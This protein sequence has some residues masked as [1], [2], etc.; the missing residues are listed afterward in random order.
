MKAARLE[1][2]CV[3][4][5]E[6]VNDIVASLFLKKRKLGEGEKRQIYTQYKICQIIL[7]T[8]MTTFISSEKQRKSKK[9]TKIRIEQKIKNF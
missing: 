1:I 9:K 6:K 7:K 3:V 8:R 5:T 2:C 4:A